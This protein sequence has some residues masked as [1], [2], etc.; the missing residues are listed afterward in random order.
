M[1]IAKISAKMGLKIK[2]SKTKGMRVNTRNVDKLELNGE[3]IDEVENFTYLGS[4]F[5]KDGGS[6]WDIQMRIGKARTAS[7]ILMPVWRSKVIFRKTTLRIFNTNVKSV[8]LYGSG[9]WRACATKATSNKLQSSVNRWLRSILGIYWPEVIR[10][11]ELWARTG[12]EG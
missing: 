12:Q 4:N 11:Q 6:D 1:W 10:H 9:T 8:L 7:T 3:A 5:S 2:T